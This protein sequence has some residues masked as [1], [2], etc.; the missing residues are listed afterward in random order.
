MGLGQPVAGVPPIILRNWEGFLEEAGARQWGA[1]PG[2]VPRDPLHCCVFGTHCM[3]KVLR[4]RGWGP[5]Q[6]GQVHVPPAAPGTWRPVCFPRLGW[7]R[8][9]ELPAENA[10]PCSKRRRMDLW[11]GLLASVQTSRGKAAS[12][13]CKAASGPALGGDAGRGGGEGR[14][15]VAAGRSQG[16]CG[17]GSVCPDIP[18]KVTSAFDNIHTFLQMDLPLRCPFRA[19]RVPGEDTEAQR[20]ELF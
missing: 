8:R 7:A 3:G 6:W 15:E 13:V 10:P 14:G 5:T 1:L 9:H 11:P 19:F 16:L 18:C 12:G 17:P 4:H 20:S 2:E